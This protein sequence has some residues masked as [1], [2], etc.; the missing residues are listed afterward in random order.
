MENT[1]LCSSPPRLGLIEQ[2]VY[3]V[4]D[5]GGGGGGSGGGGGGSGGGGSGGGSSG[6]AGIR[7]GGDGSSGGGTSGNR[8][9]RNSGGGGKK[10]S[11]SGSRGG[12]GGGGG[13]SGGSGGGVGGGGIG[14]GGNGGSVGSGGG[15]S[16]GGD[17]HVHLIDADARAINEFQSWVA[18][19]RAPVAATDAQLNFEQTRSMPR[20]IR[21]VH[22]FLQKRDSRAHPPRPS[23]TSPRAGPAMDAGAD[24]AGSAAAVAAHQGNSTSSQPDGLLDNINNALPAWGGSGT[25]AHS[26]SN[27]VDSTQRGVLGEV[28]IDGAFAGGGLTEE[29]WA[30]THQG[31]RGHGVSKAIGGSDAASRTVGGAGSRSEGLDGRFSQDQVRTSPRSA[32]LG[33]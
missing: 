29:G 1:L 7:G 6:G 31:G 17:G 12:G 25:L 30:F 26:A 32:L 2:H 19:G 14:G 15:S 23:Q 10:G 20:Y 11:R 5:Q 28:G 27:S 8:G 24:I 21:Q 4:G 3:Q 22:H 33:F 16:G 13:S 18:S 9:S